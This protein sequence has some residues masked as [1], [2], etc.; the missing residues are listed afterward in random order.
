MPFAAT[1]LSF[2]RV[3]WWT[4]NGIWSFLRPYIQASR[5]PLKRVKE[6]PFLQAKCFRVALPY[7]LG[8]NTGR[9]VSIN[10]NKTRK[11]FSRNIY[12]VRM[13]PQCFPVLR[14]G[15][16]VSS[17]SFCFQDANHAYAI[18]QGILTKIRAWKQLQK[19]CKRQQASTHLILRAIRAKTK[20]CA[21]FEIE[22]DHSILLKVKAVVEAREPESIS[23]VRSFLGL[24][25][26]SGRFIPDLATLACR[27]SAKT[28]KKGVEFKWGPGQAEA[29]QKL[30]NELTRAEITGILWQRWRLVLSLIQALWVWVLFLF[31]N[32]EQWYIVFRIFVNFLNKLVLETWTVGRIPGHN[33]CQSM[34]NRSGRQDKTR[35][36]LLS[37]VLQ[38]I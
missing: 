13:F 22:W 32:S 4:P 12:N 21:H 30:Q 25:N 33:V 16:I 2:T 1:S 38:D 15:N 37:S 3:S 20:F 27:A 6:S 11:H 28:E 19:F 23:E 5:F 10:V 24:V 8:L 31:S 36:I 9:S 35:F 7:C 34:F 18:R 29:F 17:V 26:Y 14:A